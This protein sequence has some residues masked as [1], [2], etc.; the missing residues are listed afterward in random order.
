G[1]RLLAINAP[2]FEFYRSGGNKRRRGGILFLEGQ[3][4]EDS[5]PLTF[6]HSDQ[7]FKQ[8]SIIVPVDFG[9]HALQSTEADRR[10]DLI[11]LWHGN[12]DRRLFPRRL[13]DRFQDLLIDRLEV[14]PR[15]SERIAEQG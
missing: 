10:K 8:H 4:F 13:C 12:A 15:E 3:D 1:P 14:H 7:K 9:G 2:T 11:H 5:F 6:R